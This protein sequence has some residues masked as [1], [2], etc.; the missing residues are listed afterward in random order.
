L[1]ERSAG[2]AV[3]RALAAFDLAGERRRGVIRKIG[4]PAR[5]AALAACLAMA[6][7]VAR[8]AEASAQQRARQGLLS[9]EDARLYYEVVGTGDPIVV[10][11]GGPGLDHAYLQPGLDALAN[12]NTLVYYDQRGTGRS[13][14]ALDP[15]G[16]NLDAFVE[17]IE[18]LRETLGY[19]RISVLAHSFGA[20]IGLEY[21]ARYPESLRGL[22]LMNPVEPG[23]RY[24]QQRVARQEA[25]RTPEDSAELATL[26]SSEG[27]AA[28]DPATVSEVYRIRFRQTLRD[29]TRISELDLDLAESTADNGPEVARLL[30]ETLGQVEWWDRLPQIDVP[31]LVLHGRYD[32]MPQVVAQEIAT[33][34]P[35]GRLVVLDSGH[36]PYLEDRDGLVSAVSSFLVDLRR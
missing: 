3:S 24:R 23:T 18:A 36:F 4:A 26:T 15:N 8:A 16:I 9:L 7:L 21:A 13:V 17:D 35:R 2:G 19:E 34:L 1:A 27:F 14:T 29:R 31:T 22:I 5:A 33:A 6:L 10:V 32:V 30:G 25:A 12:R 28:R 20:L 11:H